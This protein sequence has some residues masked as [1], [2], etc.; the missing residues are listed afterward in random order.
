MIVSVMAPDRSSNLTSRGFEALLG[1]LGEDREAAAQAYESLRKGLIAFFSWRGGSHPPDHA[2]DTLDR[3]ARRLEEGEPVE[4]VA[5]YAYGVARRVLLEVP[6]AAPRASVALL[7]WRS[8]A[9]PEG[10]EGAEVVCLDGCLESLPADARALIVDYYRG[11][12]RAHLEERRVLAE[13]LG[14]TYGSL[15]TRA[16]RI[17]TEL[18]RCLRNC[19][20]QP[21]E[22]ER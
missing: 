2:D 9:A 8:A 7:E 17:R 11:E 13:R 10:G 18:E 12:G 5:R 20:G 16:H 6:R 21:A 14:I 15:K 4:D 22:G 1:R 19:L 3:L